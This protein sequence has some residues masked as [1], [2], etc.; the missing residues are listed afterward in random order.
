MAKEY[1]GV[2]EKLSCSAWHSPRHENLQCMFLSIERKKERKKE[3]KKEIHNA[4]R[5]RY[6]TRL[7]VGYS[8]RHSVCHLQQTT[9]VEHLLHSYFVTSR[10][11]RHR[12][13]FS[14]P[15]GLRY[16]AHRD[17]LTRPQV[18]SFFFSKSSSL[19]KINR[20]RSIR[21]VI[22][23]YRIPSASTRL[24]GPQILLSARFRFNSND[25]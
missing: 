4:R 25:R 5:V 19:S 17:V 12:W 18:V 14:R 24:F 13:L 20:V 11:M 16:A 7:G 6:Q 2:R 23:A 1:I 15:C 8:R 3:E 9:R 21:N 10:G 22:S